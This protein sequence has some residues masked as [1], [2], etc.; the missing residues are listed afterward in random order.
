LAGRKV[1]SRHTS[2][3]DL[4]DE[5]QRLHIRIEPLPLRYIFELVVTT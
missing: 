4:D 5:F 1:Q 2:M 3:A